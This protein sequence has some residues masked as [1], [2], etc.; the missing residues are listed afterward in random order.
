[1]AKTSRILLENDLADY[2]EDRNFPKLSATS[3][4]SPHLHFESSIHAPSSLSA[5]INGDWSCWAATK[6]CRG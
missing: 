5:G 6:P 4:L 3:I 2:D 1:M